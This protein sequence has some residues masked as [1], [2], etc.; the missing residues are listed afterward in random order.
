M[1]GLQL[2]DMAVRAYPRYAREAP[3]SRALRELADSAGTPAGRTRGS[4]APSC[5]Y[6]ERRTGAGQVTIA[7]HSEADPADI[8]RIRMELAAEDYDRSLQAHS[9]QLPAVAE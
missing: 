1:E 8:R 2:A 4:S 3:R 7:G 5:G 6:T 9:R